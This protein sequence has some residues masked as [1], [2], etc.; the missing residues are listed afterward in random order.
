MPPCRTPQLRPETDNVDEK[1]AVQ[2]NGR[3]AGVKQ[4]QGSNKKRKSATDFWKGDWKAESRA[5]ILFRHRRVH[6]EVPAPGQPFWRSRH[7]EEPPCLSRVGWVQG[8]LVTLPP[9]RLVGPKGSFFRGGSTFGFFPKIQL[10]KL[11][12]WKRPK[13]NCLQIQ[14][15]KHERW[16]Q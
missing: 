9:M 12:S 3:S 4:I 16:V 10:K 2:Q 7:I 5:M 15:A 11:S 8:N 14:L 1:R 13:N 6:E